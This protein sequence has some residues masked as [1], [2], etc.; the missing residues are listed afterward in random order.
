MTVIT[1]SRKHTRYGEHL[2]SFVESLHPHWRARRSVS[3]KRTRKQ[4]NSVACSRHYWG[5]SQLFL[6][7]HV[8]VFCTIE[9]AK[10][11]KDN[12]ERRVAVKGRSERM[13]NNEIRTMITLCGTFDTSNFRGAL[14]GS[15]CQQHTVPPFQQSTMPS[16]HFLKPDE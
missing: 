7:L 5:V 4:H 1:T 9:K 2:V 16:L 11:G 13:R 6:V 15:T 3:L 14:D 12:K 10:G 8:H